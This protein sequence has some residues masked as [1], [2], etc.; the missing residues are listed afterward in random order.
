MQVLLLIHYSLIQPFMLQA[1]IIRYIGLWHPYFPHF[2]RAREGVNLRLGLLIVSLL[3]YRVKLA[4]QKR[5]A[6]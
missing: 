1:L 6:V 3:L 5:Y 4:N 2:L